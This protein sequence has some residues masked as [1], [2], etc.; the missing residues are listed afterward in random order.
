MET[1]LCF[2]NLREFLTFLV[3]GS[4]VR[5]YCSLDSVVLF[6]VGHAI[7][8]EGPSLH[9]DPGLASSVFVGA[10]L[11]LSAPSSVTTSVSSHL[12]AS[13][14][15]D[16]TRFP[17]EASVPISSSVSDPIISSSLTFPLVD[18]HLSDDIVGVHG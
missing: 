14:L 9:S 16:S 2:W 7:P 4:E 3:P 12:P 13:P 1:C 17:V 11:A 18:S 8:L 15:V 5:V 10:S 6:P